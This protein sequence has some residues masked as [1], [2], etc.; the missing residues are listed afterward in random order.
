MLNDYSVEDLD[1]AEAKKEL[2]RLNEILNTAN[3]DYYNNDAP[4]LSDS[5]YDIL[6]KRNSDIE[7]R[8]PHLKLQNSVSNKVGSK[9][10]NS[11]KKIKHSVKMLSLANGFDEQDIIDFDHRIKKT[12]GHEDTIITYVAE[13]KI[14][15]L[16][17]S[18]KY[19]D[20]KLTQATTRGD[21]EVGENVTENAK[22]IRNI[23]NNIYN[24][25]SI[26]EVRGEVYMSMDDFNKLNI[27][28]EKNNAKVFAN[29]RNAAAGS[30]RQ[31]D[32]SV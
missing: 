11:F 5:E 23:P 1:E 12:L 2:I 7:L 20:G 4:N 8:F 29:P 22:T 10:S 28:Q 6:K 30:L 3:S 9:P 32:S 31:L 26:L 25:P 24:A 17:L 14:D 19:L 13:P 21:G 16:S 15:G 18:L 27:K